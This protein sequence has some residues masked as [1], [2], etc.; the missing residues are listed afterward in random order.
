MEIREKYH[1]ESKWGRTWMC[2][3]SE[4]RQ[5]NECAWGL[6]CGMSRRMT[7]TY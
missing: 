6:S 7:G 2:G 5:A 4:E 3:E 1:E